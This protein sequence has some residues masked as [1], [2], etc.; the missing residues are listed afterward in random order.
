MDEKKDLK[1]WKANTPIRKVAGIDSPKVWFY[2]G[3]ADL[4][5]LAEEHP[6]EYLGILNI[7]QKALM[8]QDYYRT[9]GGKLRIAC[10]Y[11][12]E[13]NI[14]FFEFVCSVE[15]DAIRILDVEDRQPSN[16]DW[17]YVKKMGRSVR[18]Y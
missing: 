12:I 14:R 9:E 3:E 17:K 5:S 1:I 13:G 16:G 18:G 11:V 6:N 2:I 10:S 4:N 8:R 15:E 7:W